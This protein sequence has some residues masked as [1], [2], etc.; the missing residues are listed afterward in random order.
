VHST[1][2]F[3][4]RV[5][6]CCLRCHCPAKIGGICDTYHGFGWPSREEL[7]GE[8]GKVGGSAAVVMKV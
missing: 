3:P 6:V 5:L 2:G 8:M 4:L 7:A 1:F